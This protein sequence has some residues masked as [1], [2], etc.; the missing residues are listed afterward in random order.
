V[1]LSCLFAVT[2]C[3]KAGTGQ[4]SQAVKIRYY[5]IWPL[6]DS[7]PVT[8]VYY[9]MY[10]E[11]R[12]LHPEIDLEVISDAHEAWSTKIKIMMSADDMTEVF[13]SQPKDFL[14][15]ADSDVYY[16]L[17]GYLDADPEWKDSFLPGSLE[18]MAKDGKV[19]G[20]PHSGYAAGI[21]YNK[22][23]FDKFGLSFPS[24]YDELIQCIKT[25]SAGGMDAFVVGGKDAWPVTFYTQYWMDREAGYDYF[26]KSCV[27][28]SLT[29][30]NPL[31]L[32]AI[33]KFL[34][35]VKMGAFTRGSSG[36][37]SDD[38]RSVFMQ[39]KAAM[40]IT[41]TWD[42]PPYTAD[43]EFSKVVHFANF[44]SMP[45]GK[46]VQNAA[47][48]GFGKSFCISNSATDAQKKAGI[49][50]IK[51]MNNS[52]ASGRL[53]NETGEIIA[54]RPFGVDPSKVA[55]LLQEVNAMSSAA[56][57]TWAGYGEF[58]TPG[59]YDELNKIGQ[60]LLLN[61]VSAQEALTMMEQ[62]RIEFQFNL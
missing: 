24:T 32:K 25:F 22:A 30:E 34:D 16:E 58:T 38:A 9:E 44:P 18:I 29:F 54:Q 46:G 10:D 56:D 19:Y 39:G 28:K 48:V 51:F 31:Y 41:G 35:V 49:E 27:D 1:V 8:K 21:F 11:F 3:G 57:Q 45:G 37:S 12:A 53:M 7:Q 15:Y 6:N 13:I 59:F 47:C 52:R 17:T 26:E 40:L 14:V 42:I 2:G 4:T 20:I 50:F 61:T 43:P 62:A 5:N 60:Q 33:E 23:I 36:A 55:P